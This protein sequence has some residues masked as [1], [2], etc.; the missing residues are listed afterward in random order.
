MIEGNIGKPEIVNVGKLMV[1]GYLLPLFNILVT[2]MFIRSV[3]K[4]LGGDVDI[5]GLSKVF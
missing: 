5:P 1:P 4:M 3:S 2:L